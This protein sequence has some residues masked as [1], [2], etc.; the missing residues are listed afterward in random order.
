MEFITF[1]NHDAPWELYTLQTMQ[2][3]LLESLK[4]TSYIH[5]FKR[6]KI[7]IVDLSIFLLWNG[8]KTQL[9]YLITRLNSRHAAMKFDLNIQNTASSFKTQKSKEAK[10]R[11]N[12]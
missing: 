7:F 11:T 12:Y 10:R 5:V 4:G 6:F 2:I 3:F 9:I 1:K 8:M